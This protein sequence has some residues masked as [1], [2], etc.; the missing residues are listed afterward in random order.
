MVPS[1]RGRVGVAG[2]ELVLYVSAKD[3]HHSC[4]HSQWVHMLK[5]TIIFRLAS[6]WALHMYIH[7]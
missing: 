5:I 7:I 6:H 1:T 4:T 2:A 3:D